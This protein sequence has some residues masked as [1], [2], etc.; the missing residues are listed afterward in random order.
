MTQQRFDRDDSPGGG[1]SDQTRRSRHGNETAETLD[2]TDPDV[3]NN[4]NNVRVA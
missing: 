1:C 4:N 3:V 2:R